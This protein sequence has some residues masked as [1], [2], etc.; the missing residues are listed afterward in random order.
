MER[1]PVRHN[2]LLMPDFDY[3]FRIK[4]SS[5][6]KCINKTIKQQQKQQQQLVFRV[7]EGERREGKREREKI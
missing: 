1:V 5:T 7:L 2:Q 6:Y 4:D 3:F